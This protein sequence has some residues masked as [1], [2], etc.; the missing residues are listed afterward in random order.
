ADIKDFVQSSFGILTGTGVLG[1]IAR[2]QELLAEVIREFAQAD[3]LGGHQ[4]RRSRVYHQSG[5]DENDLEAAPEPS[6]PPEG[7]QDE[8]VVFH[9]GDDTELD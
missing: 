8:E 7:H 2:D 9:T 1:L 3:E 5:G 6:T 4:A